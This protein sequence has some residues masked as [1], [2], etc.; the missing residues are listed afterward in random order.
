MHK[1]A[2]ILFLLFPIT[3]ISAQDTGKSA[4][5][6]SLI[7]LSP[8]FTE[9][10]MADYNETIVSDT[11]LYFHAIRI[12]PDSVGSW[13]GDKDFTYMQYLD[14][15]LRQRKNI[16]NDNG[17]PGKKTKPVYRN[18]RYDPPRDR[19]VSSGV[20]ETILWVFAGITVLFIGY[21][22][23]LSRGVFSKGRLQP[24]PAVNEMA[25]KTEAA[26]VVDFDD[27]IR[28]SLNAGDYRMAVRYQ[29][30]KTLNKLSGKG[31]ISLSADKTNYQYARE[32]KDV[33]QKDFSS[34]VLN[35]EYVW[36]G[37]LPINSDQ[38]AFIEQKFLH[39]NN[40]L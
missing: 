33:R 2:C 34:L 30:L 18:T 25:E 3:G 27:Q 24:A 21:R 7:N 23:L 36:Y 4:D 15:L 13:K 17:N 5:T 29:F 20:L 8:D 10:E 11:T 38:Y 1:L 32:L 35:Y 39:F 26:L 12:S 6:D 19:W 28:K 37:Q 9:E 14:S 22:L 40:Q 16:E 31:M